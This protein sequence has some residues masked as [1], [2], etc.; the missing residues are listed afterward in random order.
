[1][2]AIDWFCIRVCR[3]AAWSV[4][5]QACPECG[6]KAA[7]G[8][9]GCRA[10]FDLLLARDFSDA[11]FF[12]SHRLFVDTYALQH[13]N[14]FCASAKSFAAHLCG[15]CEILDAKAGAALG[16]EDLRRWLDG[17][18]AIERPEAPVSRGK[19]VIGDLRE[20]E[21][22]VEWSS[23]VRDW[24]EETWQAYAS[25]HPLARQWLAQARA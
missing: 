22:S 6:W 7:G 14:Q 12:A 23:R 11:A 15:I 5:M 24:A 21:N 10:Q 17:R 19:I 25:L 20:I 4:A 18:R 16:S 9:E 13:P 3:K 1:M 2:C 8:L